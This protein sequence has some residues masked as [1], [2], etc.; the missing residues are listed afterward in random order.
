V[1]DEQQPGQTGGVPNAYRNLI[2]WGWAPTMPRPLRGPFLTLL[3]A[4]GTAANSQGKL[5]FR[6]GTVIRMKDI[7][8][9]I[10]SDEKDCRR[11]LNAA[12][13]AGVVDIEGE[14]GRGK[15]ATYVIV[16]SPS[17]DWTA[18]VA[19]M[20]VSR[21]KKQQRPA[22]WQNGGRSPEPAATEE[23]G[24]N[25][26]T[27]TGDQPPNPLETRTGDQPPTE[28]GGPTP[29]ENGGPSPEQP[30]VTQVLPHEMAEAGGH[31]QEVRASVLEQQTLT[32]DPAAPTLRPVPRPAGGRASAQPKANDGSNSGQMPLLVSVRTPPHV[33]DDTAQLRATATP[34]DVRRAVTQLGR[35]E[36]IALYGWR[37]VGPVLNDLDSDSDTGS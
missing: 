13:A 8:R 18:A 12:I 5:R 19:S 7:A 31:L 29:V 25:P 1:Q 6:D 10:G 21:P 34:D 17:P 33:T 16:L 28:N 9:A 30:R 32:A 22:P 23:R 4:L 27:G 2:F 3:Y 14:R 37:L 36:A 20:A 24:T 15:R 35:S 26:R 11:Y